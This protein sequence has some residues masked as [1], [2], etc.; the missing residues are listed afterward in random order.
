MNLTNKQVKIITLSVTAFP[1]ETTAKV[2]IVEEVIPGVYKST[3]TYNMT[4]DTVYTSMDEAGL[5]AAVHDKL[6]EIP[7]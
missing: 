7:D 4:F 3:V 2:E 1:P 6:L 5:L